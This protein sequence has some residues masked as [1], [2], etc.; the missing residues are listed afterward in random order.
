MIQCSACEQG[1]LIHVRIKP[2]G[3]IGYICDEC[4]A[5]WEAE[6]VQLL[7]LNS[8]GT[9]YYARMAE[10]GLSDNWDYL[11]ILASV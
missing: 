3:L 7:D 1:S 2:T 4:E 5:F 8:D 9:A 10:L 11:E 6:S